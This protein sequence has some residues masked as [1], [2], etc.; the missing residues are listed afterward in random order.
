MNTVTTFESSNKMGIPNMVTVFGPNL[1]SSPAT[2]KGDASTQQNMNQLMDEQANVVR[3]VTKLMENCKN[4]FP[5]NIR[6]KPL[7]YRKRGEVDAEAEEAEETSEEDD[8]KNV[9]ISSMINEVL[10]NNLFSP[11]GSVSTSKTIKAFEPDYDSDDSGSSRGSFFRRKKDKDD[12][13]KDKLRKKDG[14]SPDAQS[15]QEN[16]KTSKTMQPKSMDLT[17]ELQIQLST[18]P[19]NSVS[20]DSIE[21]RINKNKKE[22]EST[23]HDELQLKANLRNS[24]TE[25]IDEALQKNKADR[26]SQIEKISKP[27]RLATSQKSNPE[28]NE[29]VNIFVKYELTWD[30][31][32]DLTSISKERYQELKNEYRKLYMTLKERESD[33]KYRELL[34]TNTEAYAEYKQVYAISRNLK[35]YLKDIKAFLNGSTDN[36]E[37]LEDDVS[38]SRREFNLLLDKRRRNGRP[39]TIQV[40]E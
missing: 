5:E 19:K 27:S 34:E 36:A 39:D 22:S 6:T 31:T 40:R 25:S 7:N 14:E 8:K 18:R 16:K 32:T 10:H 15:P 1:V 26:S 28:P 24:R 12:G 4:I 2:K 11:P 30:G 33:E 23:L 17:Q 3:I 9:V 29:Q 38:F 37:E 13:K 35:R 20:V 21:A